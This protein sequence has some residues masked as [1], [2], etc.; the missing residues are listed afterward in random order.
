MSERFNRDTL[1]ATMFSRPGRKALSRPRDWL[2]RSLQKSLSSRFPV[3]DDL[4]IFRVQES[5]G[6]LS[7]FMSAIGCGGDLR[8]KGLEH[9]EQLCKKV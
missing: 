6:V 7:H 4:A 8:S 1:S 2:I 5:V 9:L 3:A